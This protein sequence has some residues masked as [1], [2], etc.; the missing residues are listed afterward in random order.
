[1]KKINNTDKPLP[2]TKVVPGDQKTGRRNPQLHQDTDGS[3]LGPEINNQIR[4]PHPA[5]VDTKN[6]LERL[7]KVLIGAGNDEAIDLDSLTP[8]AQ[9]MIVS[10]VKD[11][12]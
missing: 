8:R 3:D 6:V 1:M 10:K 9:D 12:I 2:I 4:Q 7:N 5:V 11:N